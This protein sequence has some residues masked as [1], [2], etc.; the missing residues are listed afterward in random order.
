MLETVL[1]VLIVFLIYW[2]IVK[3][4]DNRGL[5]SK[6]NISSIGPILMIRTSRGLKFLDKLAKYKAVWRTVANLGIPLVFLSM[7]FMFSLVLLSDY[8]MFTNPP[9]ASALTNLR[10]VILLPGVNEFIPVLWGLLGLVVTLIVHEFSHA[11][12]CRVEN[13]RVKSLG[14]LLALI[15]IGGFAEPDENEL[16]NKI[17]RIQRVR[18]FAAGVVSNFIVAAIAF[19]VFFYLLGFV[20][21]AVVVIDSDV[22]EIARGSIV[23][24][25]NGF[26]VRDQADV[27]KAIGSSKNVTLKIREKNGEVKFVEIPNLMGVRVVDLYRED[28]KVYPA[29]I[30]GIKRGMVIVKIDNKAV[31]NFTEFR[32]IMSNTKPGQNVTVMVYYNGTFRTFNVTLA[33]MNGRGFLGVYVQSTDYIGGLSLAYSSYILNELKSIPRTLSSLYGWLYM[34]AMPFRFQGFVGEIK[35]YFEAPEHVFILLNAFYW[36]AWLNFYVGLFNCLP[37]IPLDGGRIFQE[38]FSY[39][40]SKRY[41]ERADEISMKVVKF[42][43]VVVFSSFLLSIIIPNMRG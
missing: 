41:R 8:I 15:P 13:V 24:E 6:Y 23:L 17:K 29:E 1:M 35:N 33:D 30:A 5:L 20:S 12:L 37:A 25:V 42:L 18:I 10:N 11:I 16:K 9:K 4:L 21:P 34:I 19:P 31:R 36:I 39:I 38:S 7:G 43:A 2:T 3:I 40:L 22:K 27:Y 14:V 26:S 32:K 28:S